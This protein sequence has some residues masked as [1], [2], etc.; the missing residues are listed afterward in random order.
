MD[1]YFNSASPFTR[2]IIANELIKKPFVVIDIGCQGGE[3]PYW[4]LLG[5]FVEI[6]AFDA[7]KEVT[8]TLAQQ[9]TTR[10]NRCYR[11]FG[12][13]NEDG[14]RIFFVKPD[15]CASSFIAGDVRARF[16]V[17][18]DQITA[19]PMSQPVE[20][21]PTS[22]GN[23]QQGAREVEIR[24]LDTLYL[25][26]IIPKADYIK[27]DCE[28]F[29]PE[30]LAG[31]RQFLAASCVL[32]VEIETNFLPS[33]ANPETHFQAIDRILTEHGLIVFDF[34]AMRLPRPAYLRLRE[35]L[36]PPPLKEQDPRVALAPFDMGQPIIF[37][38][39]YCRDLIG[40]KRQMSKAKGLDCSLTVD[41]IIKAMINF[42]RYGLMDCAVELAVE[43]R[44][45]L[46][47][48]FSVDEAIRLL[49]IDPPYA[50]NTPEMVAALTTIARLRSMLQDCESSLMQRQ[51]IGH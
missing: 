2:W 30:I 28:C 9:N 27:L 11:N 20:A 29:E 3:H 13:G 36:Q 14:R 21:M 8:E 16:V 18:G 7:I 34:A 23:P 35:A 24:R 6:H 42:E 33:E 37:N 4:E 46:E 1:L 22:T 50:R 39:L 17:R 43:F 31:A 38:F 10:P 15:N 5:D 45:E 51:S 26:G 41:H 44:A 40:E 48:R 49:L 12:L 32:C 47:Q 25:Q 19:N